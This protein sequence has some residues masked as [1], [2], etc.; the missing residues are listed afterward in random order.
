MN[1][2][3]ILDSLEYS[4]SIATFLQQM[5]CKS[6]TTQGDGHSC[7]CKFATSM[8][9]I[10]KQ[11]ES[12]GGQNFPLEEKSGCCEA[13][14]IIGEINRVIKSLKEENSSDTLETTIKKAVSE[15]LIKHDSY[16]KQSDMV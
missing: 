12:K 14:V 16:L 13:R 3:E 6:G 5:L 15:A 10:K 8:E 1:Y 2:Q 7:N 4:K 9:T 11:I